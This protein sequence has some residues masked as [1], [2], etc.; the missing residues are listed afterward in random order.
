MIPGEQLQV[1]HFNQ[2]NGLRENDVRTLGIDLEGNVWAGAIQNS[3]YRINNGPLK[4][5]HIPSSV[6][7][8]FTETNDICF[9]NY[10]H[11]YLCNVSDLVYYNG[12]PTEGNARF[13]LFREPGGSPSYGRNF[14][15]LTRDTAGNIL[16]LTSHRC[17]VFKPEKN[18]GSYLMN[19]IF[20]S[21]GD[22]IY[23]LLCDS[24]GIIWLAD[25]SGLNALDKGNNLRSAYLHD[26]LL[27]EP[28]SRIRAC[29][30]G[31]CCLQPKP[32]AFLFLM[33]SMSKRFFPKQMGLHL[34]SATV[35]LSTTIMFG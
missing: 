22:R 1:R 10:N 31:T 14:K 35:F 15:A 19:K 7:D 2:Q 28:I 34:I 29:A 9:D 18:Q 11:L 21:P 6:P 30:D 13:I 27:R 25:K 5:Y 20:Q 12:E 16:A 3:L 4:R 26:S 8:Y 23:T 32:K 17:Y 33:V 24:K